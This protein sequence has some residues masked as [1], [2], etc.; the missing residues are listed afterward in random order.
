LEPGKL[1]PQTTVTT[2]QFAA[3]GWAQEAKSY[4]QGANP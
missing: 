3:M 2:I 4:P 1:P